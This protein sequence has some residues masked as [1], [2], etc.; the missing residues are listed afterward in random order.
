MSVDSRKLVSDAI[1]IFD[2]SELPFETFNQDI[3]ID[4]NNLYLDPPYKDDY[5]DS[6]FNVAT[7][8][9]SI[10]I[11]IETLEPQSGSPSLPNQFGLPNPPRGCY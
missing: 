4:I 7:K 1:N 9:Q 6:R 11:T 3:G 10:L 2:N 5:R 8:Q